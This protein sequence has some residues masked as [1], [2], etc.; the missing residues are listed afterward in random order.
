MVV[1]LVWNDTR[2]SKRESESM[3]DRQK[4]LHKVNVL[5]MKCDESPIL[6]LS[7][8]QFGSLS[9]HFSFFLFLSSL[10]LLLPRMIFYLFFLLSH[11]YHAWAIFTEIST[12]AAMLFTDFKWK[13]PTTTTT[14]NSMEKR[15]YRQR[16]R[17]Q[18]NI[19]IKNKR[20]KKIQEK[21]KVCCQRDVH[22]IKDHRWSNR[23]NRKSSK[24]WCIARKIISLA[25]SLSLPPLLASTVWWF[26]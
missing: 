25:L 17:R 24:Q 15:D 21:I 5:S 19:I 22:I 1:V 9:F 2:A 12:A 11:D 4:K 3:C 13:A 14:K 23:I 7:F 18:Y 20:R 26:F 6:L 16:Q 8:V 10:L